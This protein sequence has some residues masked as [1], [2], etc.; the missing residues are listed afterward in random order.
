LQQLL[1]TRRRRGNDPDTA[2]LYE[3]QAISRAVS[4]KFTAA[5][6]ARRCVNDGAEILFHEK[7]FGKAATDRTP[8]FITAAPARQLRARPSSGAAL[9]ARTLRFPARQFQTR[10]KIK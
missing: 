7:F 10:K 8:L 2:R 6:F 4:S 9:P 5:G 3:I 1:R